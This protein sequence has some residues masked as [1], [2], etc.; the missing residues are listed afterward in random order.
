MTNAETL[1]PIFE[2]WTPLTTF[3]GQL[4]FKIGKNNM[5]KSLILDSKGKTDVYGIQILI[6]VEGGFLTA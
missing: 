6:N 4:D 1:R 3:V 5:S 2:F